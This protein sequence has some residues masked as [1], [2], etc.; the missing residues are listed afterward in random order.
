[1]LTSAGSSAMAAAPSPAYQ[2]RLDNTESYLQSAQSRDGGFP[3]EVG[4]SSGPEVSAWAAL[5]LAAAGINPQQQKPKEGG[6][7]VYSYLTAHASE[8]TR[9]TDYARELL[10]VDAAG[11]SPYDFGEVNLV[12]EILAR[13]LSGPGE[14]GAF[15]H[16]AGGSIPGINDT[17]FAIL[18]LS[19]IKE[20]EVES[21]VQQAAR[22]LVAVHNTEG[23][24]PSAEVCSDHAER[25]NNCRSEVDMTGAAIEALNA[26]GLKQT[27]AQEEAFAFL[28]AAQNSSGGFPEFKEAPEEEPNVASSAWAVEAM[29]SAGEN[30]ESW[31]PQ[32]PG[33]VD[34][35]LGY[36]ASM[37]QADGRI[38]YKASEEQNGVWMT[39]QVAPAFAGEWLPIPAVPSKIEPPPSAPGGAGAGGESA[40]P[41]A[42]VISGGGGKGAPLFSRPQPQSQ[43][44]T[45]GGVRLLDAARERAVRREKAKAARTTKAERAAATVARAPVTIT[46]EPSK[47]NSNHRGTGSGTAKSGSGA[48]PEGGEEVR[49]ELIDATSDDHDQALEPGAPGLR[50]AGAG[51][52][53]TPW[54]AI[55]IGG[56]IGLLILT[57]S[58]FERR[59]PQVIV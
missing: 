44:H 5:G 10:V 31:V 15:T 38:R 2:E 14:E 45:P 52:T 58:Q 30:P 26:A 22:W 17:V 12:S 56:L 33:S 40:Q 7:S 41:G 37:Q 23:G 34:E 54:L 53:Q 43:G 39:A 21:V 18:A 59:R 25:G 51:G 1:M 27:Q 11:M 29:W 55:A 13:K 6:P 32:A 35:P 47:T 16:E 20:P 49:G 3:A 4:G 9:T 46:T 48:G 42:G 24:W 28:H 50:G 19:P 57:G 8:L 36:L